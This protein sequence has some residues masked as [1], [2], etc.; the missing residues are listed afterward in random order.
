[1]TREENTEAFKQLLKQF[2]QLRAGIQKIMDSMTYEQTKGVFSQFFSM[3]DP[4]VWNMLMRYYE[5]ELGVT[6]RKEVFQQ[7]AP[8]DQE[9]IKDALQDHLRSE[10]QEI[11]QAAKDFVSDLEQKRAG[12]RAQKEE[13]KTPSRKIRRFWTPPSPSELYQKYVNLGLKPPKEDI[14]EDTYGAEILDIQNKLMDRN[15]NCA[16]CAN[17][18]KEKHYCTVLKDC[19]AETSICIKFQPKQNEQ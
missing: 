13:L 4:A 9:K 19:I 11:S 2:I 17:Y 18:Q 3:K 12:S 5:T 7:L 1:M 16:Q 10:N 14:D 8:V 15:L 6:G